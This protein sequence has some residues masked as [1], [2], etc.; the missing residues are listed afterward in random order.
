MPHESAPLLS[1]GLSW[2]QKGHRVA[3]ATVVKTW[4]SSPRPAGSLLVICETG[5]FVGSV[6]GGCIEGAV[7]TAAQATMSD[8]KPQLLQFGVTQEMAWEV[9]LACG[10]RVEVFVER[11][12]AELLTR[13]VS[14]LCERRPLLVLTS[15]TSGD[16][17]LLESG[18]QPQCPDELRA[19]VTSTLQGDTTTEQELSD[20]RRFFLW[21][22]LPSVRVLIFGAVH[23]AQPLGQ[24]AQQ[25]GFD[26]TVIDPRAAFASTARFPDVTLIREWPEQALLQLPIDQRTAVVTLTHDPKLDDPALLAALRS[27]AFYVGALGSGKTHASRLRRLAE[28]ACSAEQLARIHGPVGLRI[29]ARS[30]AEIAVSILGQLISVLRR[31]R[32]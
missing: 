18:L 4:G 9:G 29:G 19:A 3:L 12:D 22:C 13:L 27:E 20:G 30:P 5:D 16:K 2:C 11:V 14:A 25:C 31:E 28:Q 17:W 7:I 1:T 6:S 21:P 15:L 10:G 32:E 8:G 23:T 26:V 24:M